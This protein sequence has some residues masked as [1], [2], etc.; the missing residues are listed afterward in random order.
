LRQN[1][2]RNEL[3]SS[4]V[5]LLEGVKQVLRPFRLPARRK[6]EDNA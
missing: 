5:F 4:P 2:G 3:V 6:G 1:P